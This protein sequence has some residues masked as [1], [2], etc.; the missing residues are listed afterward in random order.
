[1]CSIRR[2]W[3]LGSK[4]HWYKSPGQGNLTKVQIFIL[5]LTF[6]AKKVH[7]NTTVHLATQCFYSSNSSVFFM[8]KVNAASIGF[9]W[10]RKESSSGRLVFVHFYSLKKININKAQLVKSYQLIERMECN[11]S[12]PVF[13]AKL[14]SFCSWNYI[15]WT[16]QVLSGKDHFKSR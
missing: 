13:G 16:R 2:L 3:P 15:F 8:W 12:L 5:L 1:M 4:S 11:A 9:N 14:R 7:L 6:P 10:H